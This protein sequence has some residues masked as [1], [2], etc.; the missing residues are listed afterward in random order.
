MTA[1]YDFAKE[2]SKYVD[3]YVSVR[4]AVR[5]AE[6]IFLAV[7]TEKNRYFTDFLCVINYPLK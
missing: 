7:R 5:Q 6:Y 1:L 2:H 3:D 4:Y